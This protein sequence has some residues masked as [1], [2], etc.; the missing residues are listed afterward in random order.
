MRGSLRG[1]LRG[2]VFSRGF[3]RY[4]EVF[5]GF[6]S[7]VFRGPLRDPIRGRFPSQRLSVLL[8]LIVLPLELSPSLVL[9]G[10]FL[11]SPIFQG[12]SRFVFFCPFLFLGV[13]RGVARNIPK[14]VRDTIRTCAGETGNHPSLGNPLRHPDVTGLSP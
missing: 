6:L 4:S 13:V 8:P 2:R 11:I 12:F 10:T 3:E 5:R 1:L 9:F 7:E 14:R